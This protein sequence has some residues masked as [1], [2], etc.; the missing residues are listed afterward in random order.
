MSFDSVKHE[1]L[2]FELWSTKNTTNSLSCEI[3]YKFKMYKLHVRQAGL[4]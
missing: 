1:E 2:L 3:W 4:G